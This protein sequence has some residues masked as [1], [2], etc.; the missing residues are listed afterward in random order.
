MAAPQVAFTASVPENYDRYLGPMLFEP[1]AADLVARLRT[2]DGMRLLEVA[3]GTGIVTEA[4]LARLPEDSRLVATDLSEPMLM[5]ACAKVPPDPRLQWRVADAM[6]LPFP[7]GS[8]EGVVCQFGLMFV[9]DKAAAVREMRRVLLEGGQLLLNTWDALAHNDFC[10]VAHETQATFFETDP[11]AF[12]ETPFSLH[13]GDQLLAWMREAGFEQ[14]R[15]RRVDL[16]TV[17]ASA[18]DAAKGLVQ[19]T[20][21]SVALTERGA[22]VDAIREVVQAEV[23]KQFGEA[24]ARGRMRA[25]VCEAAR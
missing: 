21:L 19:G 18:A 11:P 12:F 25:L 13:D 4:L 3:C 14:P 24:P 2:F 1:Y 16:P 22:D 17:S 8:F 23:A 20:P 5:L 10:R 15:V 9:P 6:A 7:D